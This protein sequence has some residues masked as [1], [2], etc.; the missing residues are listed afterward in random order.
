MIDERDE[1]MGWMGGVRKR[2]DEIEVGKEGETGLN[3][4][5]ALWG[6]RHKDSEEHIQKEVLAGFNALGTAGTTRWRRCQG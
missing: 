5:I 1:W 6:C 2:G 3:R 4:T